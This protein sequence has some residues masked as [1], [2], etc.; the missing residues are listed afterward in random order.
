ML[1]FPETGFANQQ[2]ALMGVIGDAV[3]GCCTSVFEASNNVT[4]PKRNA[5]FCIAQLRS[6]PPI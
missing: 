4:W 2:T 1:F 3:P 6:V 5:Q